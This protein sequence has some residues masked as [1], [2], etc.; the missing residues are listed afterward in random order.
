MV[1]KRNPPSR[2]NSDRLPMNFFLMI[3]KYPRDRDPSRHLHLHQLPTIY[4]NNGVFDGANDEGDFG[5][6]L[7]VG[8]DSGKSILLP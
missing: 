7:P 3:E 2:Q 6:T 8:E 5:V 4:R 1:T